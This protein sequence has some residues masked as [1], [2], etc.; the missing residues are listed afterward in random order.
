MK[1]QTQKASFVLVGDVNAHHQ[2]WLN[3]I[4]PTNQ[5]GRGALDFSNLSGCEQI[6]QSPTHATGNCID[7]LFTDAPS[8]VTVQVVPPLG[9]TDYSGLSFNIHTLFSVPG[10]PVSR[11]VFLKSRANWA[12]VNADFNNIVGWEVFRLI[13]QSRP[14]TRRQRINVRVFMETGNG[15]KIILVC[16]SHTHKAG[17][18][19]AFS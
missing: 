18:N 2:E 11:K 6:V 10:K 3:S 17:K 5:H 1:N 16:S 15:K 8:E 19:I 14:L 12:G 9:S 7:L 4:S 13:V